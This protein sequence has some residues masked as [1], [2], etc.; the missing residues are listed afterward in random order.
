MD[1]GVE[2]GK[3]KPTQ[4][5]IS[6]PRIK[7]ILTRLLNGYYT[8]TKGLKLNPLS[9]R[10]IATRDGYILDGHHRWASLLFL[11]PNNK[12]DVLRINARI[13]DLISVSKDFDLASVSEFAYGG[14]VEVKVPNYTSSDEKDITTTIVKRNGFPTSGVTLSPTLTYDYDVATGTALNRGYTDEMF[15]ITIG[16]RSLTRNR[17]F[18]VA[19]FVSDTLNKLK[20]TDK[21]KDKFSDIEF[22]RDSDSQTRLVRSAKNLYKRYT[23]QRGGVEP[24]MIIILG[25]EDKNSVDLSIWFPPMLSNLKDDED[26]FDMF[27]DAINENTKTP[28]RNVEEEKKTAKEE[29]KKRK[30]KL[31]QV[32]NRF[33]NATGY[34]KKMK[35]YNPRTLYRLKT[36]AEIMAQYNTTDWKRIADQM[37]CDWIKKPTNR[38]ILGLIVNK[39]AQYI[40]KYLFSPMY[41][42]I[43]Q[44]SI[45]NSQM[46]RTYDFDKVFDVDFSAFKIKKN[47]IDWIITDLFT[48][49]Q[50]DF[51]TEK[52]WVEDVGAKIL[53]Q[54]ELN[55]TTLDKDDFYKT[56]IQLA[57]VDEVTDMYV[58]KSYEKWF[59]GKIAPIFESD[60]NAYIPSEI[61][62]FL[63]ML[64]ELNLN[65]KDFTTIDLNLKSVNYL[66]KKDGK[67]LGVGYDEKTI[68]NDDVDVRVV[69]FLRFMEFYSNRQFRG[70]QMS[71]ISNIL[72][73]K[74]KNDKYGERLFQYTLQVI[75]KTFKIGWLSQQPMK[76]YEEAQQPRGLQET[77]NYDYRRLTTN[78]LAV[79]DDLYNSNVGGSY[80]I[81]SSSEF[82]Q[83][84]DFNVSKFDW[85]FR[86]LSEEQC[87]GGT[88]SSM[89]MYI[90]QIF[91]NSVNY[92]TTDLTLQKIGLNDNAKDLLGTELKPEL[93]DVFADYMYNDRPYTGSAEKLTAG[94]S[95]EDRRFT[96]LAEI[97]QDGNGFRLISGSKE[98]VPIKII[99]WMEFLRDS[100][101][102][103]I[104]NSRLIDF[105][106]F[107]NGKTPKMVEGLYIQNP[108][109]TLSNIANE[110]SYND[111]MGNSIRTRYYQCLPKIT[112]KSQVSLAKKKNSF[113]Q[114]ISALTSLLKIFEADEPL[115]QK[116]IFDKISK[117]RKEQ[118]EFVQTKYFKGDLSNL[119]QLY[120]NGQKLGGQR[121]VSEIACGLQTPTGEPSELDLE[122]YKLVRTPAFKKWFGD[123]ELAYQEQDY[124]AVSK[125]I[126]PKT[127]E[128]IV[129]Y[130][131]K[132]NMKAEAT[133]FNLA[134]F[135]VKYVGTNLSYSVWFANMGNPLSV[136]YEFYAQCINPIDLSVA[137]LGSITPIEFKE[138]IKSLYG[139]EIQTRMVSE[140]RPQKIWQMLR[141]NPLMLK[142]IRD[143]T[144]YDSIILYEDNPSDILPNG[145]PNSTLDYVIFENKQLKS[146]DNRNSTFLIDS[147][148]FRF[149]DGG[150]I[151]THI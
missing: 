74:G 141:A 62:Q 20:T 70:E 78:F 11:S 16:K 59:S 133:Y 26:I 150:L 129:C 130:H 104:A 125:A 22:V 43:W 86:Y 32:E 17:A 143:N 23:D 124:S 25:T 2:V 118:E 39:D 75:L 57:E 10:L 29:S 14:K 88:Q 151:T 31:K 50:E 99:S 148:D 72:S 7:K 87:G 40:M 73:N 35:A 110:N 51:Y 67:Y 122:Q 149:D 58:K 42:G 116:M 6:I 56:A 117:I 46:F 49:E 71:N 95:W 106:Y 96:S 12:M 84:V 140:D 37:N 76:S 79:Y 109:Y 101:D 90:S 145:E 69:E 28:N 27:F 115:K 15:T 30:E 120:S 97:E 121:A 146:A 45:T 134:N 132:G 77:I 135:P 61:W 85:E 126:N 123:W 54:E 102:T 80:N 98:Y 33:S 136:I 83:E 131:G 105:S 89:S 93:V 36:E 1:F 127:A 47:E 44:S 55:S 34:P 113:E 19:S 114:R 81:N 108:Y 103:N 38:K 4:E 21:Y 66:D 9:R 68:I 63:K 48:I 92:Q 128:P 112:S 119:L 18:S 82:F 138:I 111:I 142:E 3:L 24:K 65:F 60:Y 13:N 91:F 137:K 107:Y 5:N 139:Y 100:L 41:I 53:N 147:P 52:D 8:D 144:E 94:K 64:E